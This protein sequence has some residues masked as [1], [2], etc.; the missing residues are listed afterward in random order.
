MI[1]FLKPTPLLAICLLLLSGPMANAQVRL[2]IDSCFALAER[3]YP[4]VRQYRLIE[5]SVEYS[6]ENANKS[7]LPQLSIAGQA[8]YQSAVTELPFDMPG[9]T[10]EPL[11]KDQYRLYGEVNQPITTLFTVK[12][13][14]SLLQG[15]SSIETQKIEVAL[16]KVKERIN[17]LYFGI[18]LIDGQIKQVS[19]ICKDLQTGIDKINTA[20]ANGVALPSDADNLKAELLKAK[21]RIIELKANR[22]AYTAMMGH[23]IGREIAESTELE[24]PQAIA[25][26]SDINRPELEVLDLQL[27][28]I[29]L[30]N[31]LIGYKKLPM[32][33]AFVQGGVGR[34]ALNMLSN[35]M[36]PYYLGGLR[37]N[38][39]I[40]SFYTNKNEKKLLALNQDGIGVQKEVFLFNTQVALEQQNADV[41]KAQELMESDREIIKLRERI[42]QTTQLQLENGTANSNDYLT[43][44]NA[45]DQAQQNLLLHQV[46][47]VMA[48]YNQQITSGN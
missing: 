6:I 4:L 40:S 11:S 19:L 32:L 2:S 15:N 44:V 3:N 7:T 37:F 46:Q 13:Q 16:Y 18:L 45:Q 28:N 29:H 14:K 48:Q 12:D 17:N 21:Q 10:V 22:Q 1:N 43:A 24:L 8:T 39:N 9:T 27:Q 20:I 42:K 34:P 41:L 38:W 30:Q 5:K 33:S 31:K 23:F 47:M 26:T 36:E 35:E 25:S